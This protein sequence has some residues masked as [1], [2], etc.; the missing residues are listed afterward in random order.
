VLYLAASPQD[1]KINDTFSLWFGPMIV[2]G[3]GF[4]FFDIAV[5]I[6][7]V[8]VLKGRKKEYL[9]EHGTPIETEFQSVEL[10]SSFK[11]NGRSPYRIMSQWK[12]PVTSEIHVFESE[13][14]WFDPTDH[15]NDNKIRVFIEQSN[16]RKYY[17]DVSFLPKLAA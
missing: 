12:N 7:I 14:L 11:V 2:G 10:N 8:G 5:V 17:V 13:N 9:L 1:A 3:I 15:I 16:P 4:L 6:I